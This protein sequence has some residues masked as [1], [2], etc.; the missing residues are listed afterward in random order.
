[1]Y[2]YNVH[3]CLYIYI[4]L[5]IFN[6]ICVG[7]CMYAYVRDERVALVMPTLFDHLLSLKYC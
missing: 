5:L 1:M 6:Y 4:Y 7:V 3:A 2:V